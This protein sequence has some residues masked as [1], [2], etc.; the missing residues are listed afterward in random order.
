LIGSDGFP[1]VNSVRRIDPVGENQFAIEEWICPLIVR[2][3]REHP[4]I[5]V[6]IW[7]PDP[8]D[9]AMAGTP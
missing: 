8:P 1:Y 6:L 7:H 5:A 9:R 2:H 4:K 3:V